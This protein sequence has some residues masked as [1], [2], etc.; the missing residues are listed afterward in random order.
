MDIAIIDMGWSGGVTG[1]VATAALAHQ[2][3][4]AIA[5]HDCTGPVSLAVAGHVITAIPNGLVQ[6]VSRAF[7]HGWYQDVA[8]GLP[9]ID[10]GELA[11]ADH[12]GH[13]V[14]LRADMLNRPGTTRR[15]TDFTS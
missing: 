6:E 9:I 12:A 5:P 11:L 14:S 2:S 3:G 7:Y 10:A 13:G 15:V 4:I 1:G 8:A